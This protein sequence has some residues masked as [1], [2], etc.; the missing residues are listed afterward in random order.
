M[1]AV[2]E[3]QVPQQ[4]GRLNSL[5]EKLN[6]SIIKLMERTK[7]VR[8]DKP[9]NPNKNATQPIPARVLLAEELASV[10]YRLEAHILK[11]DDISSSLEI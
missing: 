8:F 4:V 6:D 10:C 5:C 1:D 2:K 9:E 7:S 3:L 11:L